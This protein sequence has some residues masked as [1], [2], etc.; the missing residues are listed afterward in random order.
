MPVYA[1]VLRPLIIDDKGMLEW[2]QAVFADGSK[3]FPQFMPKKWKEE[4]TK[5]G[6]YD[7]IIFDGKKLWGDKS[8][9]EVIVFEPKQIKSAIGN[10]GNYNPDDER[11]TK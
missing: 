9:V 7:G 5:D 2:A 8:H 6:E 1:K 4:V 3:E 11:I 10:D